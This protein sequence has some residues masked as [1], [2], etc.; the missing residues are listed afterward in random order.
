MPHF[1]GDKTAK[2]AFVGE[3]LGRNE[4]LQGRPFVGAAGDVLNELLNV[5]GLF[6]SDLYIT[7]VFSFQPAGNRID[8][9]IRF[10]TNDRCI[11]ESPEY[12]RE[13]ARLAEELR[14]CKAN[15]LV[16]LGNIPLYAICGKHGI[17]KQRGSILECTLPGLEGRKCIPTI[18]PAA[19]KRGTYKYRYYIIYDLMRI[20]RDSATPDLN[21]PQYEMELY[22]TFSQAMNWLRHAQTLSRVGSDIESIYIKSDPQYSELTHFAIAINERQAMCFALDDFSIKEEAVILREY[23]RLSANPNVTKVGQR[24]FFD[25]NYLARRYNFITHNVEDT[26]IA[27]GILT[28]DHPRDL[29]FLCSLWTRQPYYKDDRKLN[30]R[31]QYGDE[32][33]FR[34]YNCL[35]SLTILRIID[36]Q[37]RELTHSGHLWYFYHKCDLLESLLFIQCHGIAVDT[38]VLARLSKEAQEEMAILQDKVDAITHIH[39]NLNSPQQLMNYFY[40]E[41]GYPPYKKDGKPTVDA[42]AM[43]RLEQTKKAPE[44]RLINKYRSLRTLDSTFYN[45]KLDADGRLRCEFNPIGGGISRLSSKQSSFGTGMNMQNL[46]L[47]V[48]EA[49]IADPGF[50]ILGIDMAQAENRVVAYLW[51]VAEMIAAFESKQDVHSKTAAL[52]FNKPVNLISKEKG[53]TSIGGGKYSERDVGKRANHAFN[54]DLGIDTFAIKNEIPRKDAEFIRNSYFRAYQEIKLG[55]RDIQDQLR[56][57]RKLTNLLGR[58]ARFYNEIDDSLFREGYAYVPQTTVGDLMNMYGVQYVYNAQRIFRH[59]RLVDQIHDSIVMLFPTNRPLSELA[60]GLLHIRD[61]LSVTLTCPNN[62]RFSIPCDLSIGKNLHDVKEIPLAEY[63][64][65]T[66]LA[67]KL[68][69]VLLCQNLT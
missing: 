18:H 61:N 55:H 66:E 26:F 57:T 16:P 48:K 7:N 28:P 39:L 25:Q 59:F 52:I 43:I 19:V 50:Y 41:K 45:M 60:N 67:T 9:Y 68:E 47:S 69:E 20:K 62:N 58:S 22:P 44:A 23:A 1:E 46:P 10:D 12:H 35:D 6:R 13:R 27:Q 31:Q 36:A 37:K 40:I 14:D 56:R 53:S 42:D 2:I 51:D 4:A 64:N 49:L 38:A 29:G 11:Y 21:L 33:R 65:T 34:R 30:T 32:T 24:Y 63:A 3:A 54:Y 8:K 17:M 5:C 15:V